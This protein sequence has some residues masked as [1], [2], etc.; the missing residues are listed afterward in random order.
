MQFWIQFTALVCVGVFPFFSLTWAEAGWRLE[1]GALMFHFGV[2][3]AY[4]IQNK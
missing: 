2:S 1:S 3:M 4:L